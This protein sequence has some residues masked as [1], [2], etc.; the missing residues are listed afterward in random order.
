MLD[1]PFDCLIWVCGVVGNRNAPKNLDPNQKMTI[2]VS[3]C[4]TE[5]MI[6]VDGQCGSPLEP[7]EHLRIVRSEKYTNLVVPK[8]YDFFSLLNEKL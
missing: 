6:T 2:E 1:N 8:D 7:G 5:I 3:S 4:R